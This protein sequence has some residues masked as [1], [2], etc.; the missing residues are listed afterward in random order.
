MADAAEACWIKASQMK[1]FYVRQGYNN[2]SIDSSQQKIVNLK[3][4]NI[5]FAFAQL[6]PE[7][8][9]AT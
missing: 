3:V 7:V 5:L 9:D 4:G 1:I 6:T 2:W 8:Q